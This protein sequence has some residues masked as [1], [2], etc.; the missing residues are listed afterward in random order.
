[1]MAYSRVLH[2][3]FPPVEIQCTRQIH[4]IPLKLY[5]KYTYQGQYSLEFKTE[6]KMKS[7]YF[8]SSATKKIAIFPV[9]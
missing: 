1:M 9:D 7:E 2:H 4:G 5:G 8:V 3:S 6:K